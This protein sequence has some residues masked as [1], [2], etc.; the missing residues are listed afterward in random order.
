MHIVILTPLPLERD[1]VIKHL[2][3]SL[4][5]KSIEGDN[6]EIGRFA[7]RHQDYQVVVHQSGSRN[8]VA[9]MAADKAVRLF[10]PA[11]VLLVGVAGGVK[12]AAIGD[13]VVA[14]RAYGYE[15]G[16]ETPEGFKSRPQAAPFSRELLA[17]AQSV[18]RK[19]KWKARALVDAG[20]AQVFFG[21]I[22]SGDKV[23]ASTQSPAYRILKDHYNDTLALEM[24]SIG[25]GEAM[26]R[27]PLVQA[28]NIRGVSDLLDEK[29]KSDE[30]GAQP[31]AAGRAAAFAFE[32]LY[33][34][35][36]SQFKLP[37]MDLKP[38]VRE[39]FDHIFPVLSGMTAATGLQAALLEKARTLAP[40]ALEDLQ[41]D[42]DDEDMQGGLR[43][44]LQK[45]LKDNETAQRELTALLEKIKAEKPEASISIENSKNV[46]AG[47]NI[48]VSGDFHLGDKSGG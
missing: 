33:Q 2:Q 13:V 10:Q 3:G 44:Q 48:N 23:I 29:T 38:L 12:D 34:L 28:I 26:L 8:S 20:A 11:A 1:A 45:A 43:A 18:E 40:V 17:V 36:L 14:T 27:H 16:K 32:L 42:P 6:Y 4:E 5:E 7:G 21:P 9:A 30:S 25:F 35:D 22:A 31:L 46:I 41:S 15:S 19:G 39:V 47:S 24:E 37:H